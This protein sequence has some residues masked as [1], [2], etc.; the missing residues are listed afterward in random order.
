MQ[1]HNDHR[2]VMSLAVLAAAAGLPLTVEDAQA[3][4]KSWPGFFTAIKPLGVEV[5][6]D[7]G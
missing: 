1:G 7:V 4:E 5:N 2:V 3:V 6:E